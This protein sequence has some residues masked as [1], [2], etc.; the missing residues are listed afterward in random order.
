MSIT[1]Q[2][3]VKGTDYYEFYKTTKDLKLDRRGKTETI[4]KG[5]IVGLRPAGSKKGTWRLVSQELGVSIIFSI[6][7]AQKAQLVRF[8]KPIMDTVRM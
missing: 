5:T 6:S 3:D 4:P 7:D 1:V 8:M 2:A